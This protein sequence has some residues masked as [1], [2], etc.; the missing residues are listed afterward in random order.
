[1]DVRTLL[2]HAVHG[3]PPQTHIFL[4]IKHVA[5]GHAC[6]HVCTCRSGAWSERG[7]NGLGCGSLLSTTP[8]ITPYGFAD[9]HYISNGCNNSH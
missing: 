1:M 9:Y 2:A 7:L 4:L 5:C 3:C 8:N 6:L